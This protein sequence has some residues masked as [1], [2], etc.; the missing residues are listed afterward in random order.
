MCV[1]L[2]VNMEGF[3][4]KTSFMSVLS[5][6]AHLDGQRHKKKTR[7]LPDNEVRFI[8]RLC[9]NV[10]FT[11][12]EEKQLEEIISR[13][14]CGTPSTG[15][16]QVIHEQLVRG[17]MSLCNLPDRFRY[18]GDEQWLREHV[19]SHAHREKLV[20]ELM[21]LWGWP[22]RFRYSAPEE[23]ERQIELAKERTSGH[24]RRLCW[25]LDGNKLKEY[26]NEE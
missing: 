20:E 17:L 4:C 19:D 21:R 1:T 3:T 24:L 16:K 13:I 14:C 5:L 18:S 10:T 2:L 22:N 8:C 23:I 6:A 11:D 7:T 25:V 12:D 15:D 26:C 9:H